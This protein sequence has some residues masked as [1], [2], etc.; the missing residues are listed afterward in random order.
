MASHPK[1]GS[2]VVSAWL[3]VMISLGIHIE[4]PSAVFPKEGVFLE[5]LRGFAQAWDPLVGWQAT[6]FHDYPCIWGLREFWGQFA[7][8]G[9]QLLGE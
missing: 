2:H 7:R 1:D 8:D 5:H 4:Q 3:V 9:E 6:G